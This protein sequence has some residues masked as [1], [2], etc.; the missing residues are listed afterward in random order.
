MIV[1]SVKDIIGFI[2]FVIATIICLCLYI[3][4][5]IKQKKKKKKQINLQSSKETK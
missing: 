2:I 1:I 3:G 5:K 4:D